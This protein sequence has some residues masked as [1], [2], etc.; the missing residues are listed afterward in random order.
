MDTPDSYE[1]YHLRF[2]TIVES[3]SSTSRSETNC[4]SE[5][6]S[7]PWPSNVLRKSE[8]DKELVGCFFLYAE[9][10]FNH[11]TCDEENQTDLLCSF[12]S[13]L[14]LLWYKWTNL[15]LAIDVL[16]NDVADSLRKHSRNTDFCVITCFTA[17]WFNGACDRY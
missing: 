7:V 13:D 5:A 9:R 6:A 16:T 10:R 1:N 8:K 4:D 12:Q 15:R 14:R 2:D 3:L 11:L 17:F